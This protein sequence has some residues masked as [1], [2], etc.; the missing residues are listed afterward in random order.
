MDAYERSTYGDRVADVYDE[1]YT[2]PPDT[3]ACVEFLATLAGRGPALELGI[4]TGRVAL[5]LT[6]R[7]IDVHGIDASKS[8]VAKLREKE[9]GSGIPVTMGDFVDVGVR[10]RYSMVFIVFNT[11][12]ALLTHEDQARC[13]RNVAEHLADDG[14]F[15]VEAFV[16][17]PGRFDLGQRV[18][19]TY[20][21]LDEVVLE[22]SRHDEANQRV[23]SQAIVIREGA[24]RLF[25]VRIRYVYPAELDAMAESAGLRL[26]E[27][28]SGWE[29]EPFEDNSPRHVSVYER[30]SA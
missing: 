4:G 8:M 13:V 6:A 3:D 5:P 17:D 19:A 20:V 25:P 10:G 11:L 2:L 22:A 15:V 28:W 23:D 21:G 16:P 1:W 24:I 7:G 14:L 27:R 26:R 12:Y 30:A 18:N 29:R 9:G